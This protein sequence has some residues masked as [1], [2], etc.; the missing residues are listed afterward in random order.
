MSVTEKSLQIGNWKQFSKYVRSQNC[1]LLSNLS[2]YPDSVL[3]AGCQRSGTTAIANIITSS[4][5]MIN[6][7][8]GKDSELDAA[9][10]LSGNVKHKSRGRYCFQTTYLNERYTDYYKHLNNQF[11]LVWV[12]RNPHSVVCSM[13]H[14]WG[15]FAF[16]ELFNSCGYYLLSDDEKNKFNKFGGLAISRV[17]QACMSYN[18]KGMQILELTKNI[19]K[20]MIY[21]VDYDELILEKSRVLPEIY[22]FIGLRYDKS[23]GAKLH[24]HSL[25]KAKR[26]SSKQGSK[27]EEYCGPIYRQLKLL[28]R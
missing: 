17:H 10:I 22:K 5:G 3:V 21:I 15:S 19:K 4:D 27:I 14:N 20:E 28:G 16:K 12:I 1:D 11:K 18:G 7:W 6:Y 9:L 8:F 23:Y 25:N 26:F 24:S 2:E 13:L